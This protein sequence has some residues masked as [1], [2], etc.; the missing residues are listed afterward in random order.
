M[1]ALMVSAVTKV[2]SDRNPAACAQLTW[3]KDLHMPASHWMHTPVRD[4]RAPP[5]S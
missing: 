3:K 4:S 1:A 2:G 5:V